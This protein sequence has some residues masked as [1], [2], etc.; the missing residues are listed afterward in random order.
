MEVKGH[1]VFA[2]GWETC[3]DVQSVQRTAASDKQ[4]SLFQAII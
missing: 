3:D 4:S 2:G 1:F